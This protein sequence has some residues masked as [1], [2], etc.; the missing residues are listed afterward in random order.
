MFWKKCVPWLGS[1]C[2]SGSPVSTITLA[3]EMSDQ[4]H[5]MPSQR[6][7]DPRRPATMRTYSLSSSEALNP[8]SSAAIALISLA[9]NVSGLMATMSRMPSTMP[10]PITEV[11]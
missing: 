9:L 7:V 6:S 3:C 2:M 11:E 10:L 5:G 8:A 4:A 1:T